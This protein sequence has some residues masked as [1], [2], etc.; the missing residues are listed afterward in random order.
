MSNLNTLMALLFTLSGVTH[1]VTLG[2]LSQQQDQ[3]DRAGLQAKV[4]EALA[5]ARGSA[6]TNGGAPRRGPVDPAVDFTPQGFYGFGER[7][8]AEVAFQGIVYTRCLGSTEPI[9]GWRLTRLTP[10]KATFSK[11]N[12]RRDV[13][14]GV[15]FGGTTGAESRGTDVADLPPAPFR[16]K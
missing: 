12:A 3:I 8:C 10:Q 16:L 4:E 6:A 5:K 15:V 7:L 14:M 2:E 1:A 13:F 11:G 9:A